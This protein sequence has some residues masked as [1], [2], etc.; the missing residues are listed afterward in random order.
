MTDMRAAYLARPIGVY[1]S[2]VGGLSVLLPLREL[3]PNVE[4][5]YA[6]DQAW[7]PYGPRSAEVIRERA[8]AVTDVLVKRGS[9]AIVVA[10]NAA[11]TAAL[12]ALRTRYPEVPFIGMEPAVKPAAAQTQTGHVGVLATVATAQGER[13]ARLIDRFGRGVTVHVHVP[14]GLVELVEA[15]AGESDASAALLA[16][17]LH[18]WMEAGVDTVVLGCTHYPFARKTI[19][20]LLGNRAEVI[21]PGPAVA[22]QTARVLAH[23]AQRV[24][25][26]V[27]TSQARTVFLTSGDPHALR[28]AIRR[29][30]GGRMAEDATF[31]TFHS[32]ATHLRSA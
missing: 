25:M 31:D 8:F 10:C 15:G 28:S 22:R 6:A 3:L 13:L 20:R 9:G 24:A 16:P 1:D 4:V 30:A 17:V 26:H 7:C 32:D 5:I 14:E 11:S 12:G 23:R 19:E 21:D 18:Q 29:L 27:V 2:G